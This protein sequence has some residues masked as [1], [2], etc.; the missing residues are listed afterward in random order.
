MNGSTKRLT[1][2][3]VSG[4]TNV[5]FGQSD[6]IVTFVKMIFDKRELYFTANV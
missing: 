1:Y 5:T 2:R 6:L 3:R 4:F